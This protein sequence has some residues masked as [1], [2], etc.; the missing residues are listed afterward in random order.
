MNV[1]ATAVVHDGAH[2]AALGAD[3]RVV[4]PGGNGHLHLLNVGLRGPELS[5]TWKLPTQHAQVWMEVSHQFP[6]DAEDSISGCLTVHL[7]ARDDD[8]LRVAVLRRQVDLGVG[9]LT[10]L[11]ASSSL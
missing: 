9:L 5:L 3:Q 2:Q 1:N 6:L 4:Q 10:D 8:H 7:L 11:S